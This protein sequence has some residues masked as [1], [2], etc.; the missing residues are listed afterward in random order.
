[1]PRPGEV[2]LSHRGVLFLDELAEF[3][4]TVLEVLR[5]PIEDKVVTVSGAQG[6]KVTRK[7]LNWRPQTGFEPEISTLTACRLS[8]PRKLERS[9]QFKLSG[10]QKENLF[11]SGCFTLTVDCHSSESPVIPY[12]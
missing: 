3:G 1:M 6:M 12:G 5:Q 8:W 4:H 11:L 9:C 2:T 7:I 10:H